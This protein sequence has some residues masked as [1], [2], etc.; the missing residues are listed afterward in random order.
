MLCRTFAM[1][2]TADYKFVVV[3]SRYQGKLLL[4]R[5]RRRDTWETQGGHVEKG[6]TPEQAARRE[7]WEES[8]ATD[9]TL[10]PVCGYWAA[11]DE[12]DTGANGALFFAEITG[13]GS[14]PESE[15][16]ETRLFDGLPENLTYPDITPRLWEQV[17]ARGF[18]AGGAECKPFLNFSG[19]RL[20]GKKGN[21][22]IRCAKNSGAVLRG[23]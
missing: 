1:E 19:S 15:M 17:L 20:T 5:H 13:L 4:S 7:L 9:F 21:V 10:T 14:M 16:A 8:G 3:L 22:I 6:E 18:W 23:S 12:Q 2:D 11:D